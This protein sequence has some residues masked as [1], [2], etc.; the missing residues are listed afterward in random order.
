MLLGL[1]GFI[2]PVENLVDGATVLIN[3][4]QSEVVL[5]TIKGILG[6]SSVILLV[7]AIIIAVRWKLTKDRHAQLI[8]YLDR[9]RS[10]LIATVEEEEAILSILKPLI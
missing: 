3:Q 1:S 7:P 9:K 8:G 6:F 5:F 4:T 2:K 10:G